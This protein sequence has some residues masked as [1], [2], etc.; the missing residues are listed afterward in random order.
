VGADDGVVA[1]LHGITTGNRH[2]SHAVRV[3][4]G[5]Q[6]GIVARAQLL[7]A[8][9]SNSTVARALRSGA[10]HRVHPGVYSAVAPELLTKDGHLIAAVLAVGEGALL[11]HGTAAWR[12]RIIAAPPSVMQLAVPQPRTAPAGVTLHQSARLRP[13]DTTLNGRFPTTA[14]PRTLLDL[15]TRYD[16]RALLRALAEAE[17]HHDL[18]PADVER[19]LRRGHPGSA[20]LRAALHEHARPATA[21]SRASSSGAFARCSSG[22]GS[23]CR[24]ATRNSGPGRSTAS[25]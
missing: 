12:W 18:H 2:R 16:H 14:V 21:R 25:G 6:E 1:E 24:C 3:I 4:A 23:S 9:V 17:F 13:G 8:G 5:Q 20:N 22:A 19:T 15:A 7:A 10:L 11:S